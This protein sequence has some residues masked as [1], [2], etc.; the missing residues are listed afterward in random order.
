MAPPRRQRPRRH[1]EGATAAAA[2]PPRSAIDDFAKIDLRAA[3][4]LA[5]RAGAQGRQAAQADPRHRR[6]AANRRVR[7]RRRLHARNNR[8][9]DRDLPP[10]LA[11]R[12]SAASIAGHDPR[13]RATPRCSACL[14]SIATSL[15][16]PKSDD[17]SLA[18]IGPV[19][20]NQPGFHAPFVKEPAMP[21]RNK[22]ALIGAGNIGGELAALCAHA[23]A[24][25]RRAVRHPGEGRLR[26]GQGARSRAE[27]RRPRL[28]RRHHRHLATGPTAPAP[29]S[30]II[31]A[32]V[33]RKPGM[34]RDDLVGINLQD[35]PQRRGEPEEA[36]PERL[37]HRRLE[38]AR[39]DG[40]RAARR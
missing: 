29:T 15:R 30:S 40:L 8:R 34:S 20:R 39:R 27:R 16:E 26:Q 9:Q 5:R 18:L 11:P 1:R 14:R 3:K 7:H 22:I 38:P 36:R 12:R 37:R 35:H 4:V 33:P 10:N 31:T 24:R 19:G 25:R 13:R 32:G 17:F 2:A 6:R 21:R 23:G 28:R